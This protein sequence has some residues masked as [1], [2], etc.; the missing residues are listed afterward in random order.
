MSA[1]HIHLLLNHFPTI[2]F[3]IG[4][5]VFIVAIARKSD[6]LLE[7]GLVIFFLTAALTIVTYVSGN[8]AQ[9]ALTDT[10]GI[11]DA[12]VKAHESA[13]LVAFAFMQATGFFSWIGL[14]MLRR[15]SHVAS[16]NLAVSRVLPHQFILEGTYTGSK[17]TH[18]ETDLN[19][20]QIGASGIAGVRPFPAL[21][22]SSPIIPG[23]PCATPK[24]YH[25]VGHNDLVDAG[26]NSGLVRQ[27]IPCCTAMLSSC[28]CSTISSQQA[29][30]K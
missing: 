18:L 12:L 5:I 26:N 6:D 7:A 3:C 19:L 17:G 10:P 29:F 16:W 24:L 23:T 20:N 11:S 8:D 1:A 22:P 14:W 15:I 21:S 9:A 27:V 30:P 2:G 28:N 25:P 4:I 13:A